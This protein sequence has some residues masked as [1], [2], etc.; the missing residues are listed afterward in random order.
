MEI[1]GDYFF[2]RP[3]EE[4]IEALSGTAHTMEAI[5]ERLAQLPVNEYFNGITSDEILQLFF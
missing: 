1:H 5:S 2:T 4:F 3:T